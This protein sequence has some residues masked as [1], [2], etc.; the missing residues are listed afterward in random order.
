MR[1]SRAAGE[2]GSGLSVDRS[3]RH[4]VAA[5]KGSESGSD[6]LDG[7]FGALAH[8]VRRA[9][10]GRLRE[11]AASA[12]ELGSSFPL[13]QP[14]VS[15]HLKVLEQAGL[16]TRG[17]DAQWRPCELRWEALQEADAWLEGFRAIWAARLDRLDRYIAGAGVTGRSPAPS[18]PPTRGPGGRGT[19]DRDD[20]SKE[21][22]H[23]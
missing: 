2:D 11:G 6:R 15:K 23:D 22:D 7:V 21:Q 19:D 16:I 20:T 8:P 12:T 17:R 14:A 5:G 13:S 1:G 18:D 9:M 3:S 4:A 10:L